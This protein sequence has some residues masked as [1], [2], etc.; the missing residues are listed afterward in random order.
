MKQAI[1][2]NTA[3]ITQDLLQEYRNTR[4]ESALL[5]SR[6]DHIDRSP[7]FESAR[8]RLDRKEQDLLTA[9]SIKYSEALVQLPYAKRKVVFFEDIQ[10]AAADDNLELLEVLDLSPVEL[11]VS[12]IRDKFM[13]FYFTDFFRRVQDVEQNYYAQILFERIL[14]TSDNDRNE[15]VSI[16]NDIFSLGKDT[17]WFDRFYHPFQ[18]LL[19]RA[20]DNTATLRAAARGLTGTA[21]DIIEL[22]QNYVMERTPQKYAPVSLQNFHDPQSPVE[23]TFPAAIRP[24]I[25]MQLIG[26]RSTYRIK[27]YHSSH[28]F[29]WEAGNLTYTSILTGNYFENDR[30]T[31]YLEYIPMTH[32]QHTVRRLLKQI[33]GKRRRLSRFPGVRQLVVK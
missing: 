7:E 22:C 4:L 26:M 8:R 11:P 18:K 27:T 21:K 2:I 6:Y 30:Y 29:R 33:P 13:L 20:P 31:E 25:G 24:F 5:W 9:L 12:F 19:A 17:N 28:P 23:L 16:M 3:H 10:Q 14:D 1:P 32:N 15:Y